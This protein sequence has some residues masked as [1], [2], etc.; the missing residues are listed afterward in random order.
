MSTP[1]RYNQPVKEKRYPAPE[2]VGR[3][4]ADLR[5]KRGLSQVSMAKA[6]G[7]SQKAVSHYE[8]GS[9]TPPASRVAK[10][11]EVLGISTDEILGVEKAAKD[12]DLPQ[13][14][15]TWK[16]LRRVMDLPTRA[17]KAVF[18]YIDLQHLKHTTAGGRE[19]RRKT[20]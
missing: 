16:R 13:S 8:R 6:V 2:N 12:P 1:L 9:R 7:I 19:R 4:I 5:K 14:V 20:A 10:I 3:R 15:W 17:R 18:N 11:A